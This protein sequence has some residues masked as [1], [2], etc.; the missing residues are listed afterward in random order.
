M[1]KIMLFLSSYI[2]LIRFSDNFE[3]IFPFNLESKSATELSFLKAIDESIALNI[4]FLFKSLWVIPS[5]ERGHK[6]DDLKVFTKQSLL[7]LFINTHL[8]TGERAPIPNN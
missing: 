3:V 2:V 1:R 6:I 8:K 7:T 4:K 5:T